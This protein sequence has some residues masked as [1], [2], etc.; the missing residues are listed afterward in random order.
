MKR[1]LRRRIYLSTLII[2]EAGF[3]IFIYFSLKNFN[4]EQFAQLKKWYL[5]LLSMIFLLIYNYSY[6]IALDHRYGM[7]ISM[8]KIFSS[9]NSAVNEYVINLYLTYSLILLCVTWLIIW[10]TSIITS[11]DLQKTETFIFNLYYAVLLSNLLWMFL[12]LL[13]T[14]LWKIPFFQLLMLHTG[15]DLNEVLA[16]EFIIK[17]KRNDYKTKLVQFYN[18]EQYIRYSNQHRRILDELRLIP[19]ARAIQF[20]INHISITRSDEISSVEEDIRLLRE[21]LINDLNNVS[22][23]DLEQI[24]KLNEYKSYT[25]YKD[26]WVYPDRDFSIKKTEGFDRDHRIALL[27]TVKKM[28]K[29]ELMRRK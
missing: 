28:A 22:N 13:K 6:L 10:L 17:G 14:R 21:I 1:K 9:F 23:D 11:N 24:L 19:D 15:L 8:T 2:S 7:K 29:K 16:C 20:I 18:K 25:E 27:P 3:I 12:F 4:I 26:Y 5:I